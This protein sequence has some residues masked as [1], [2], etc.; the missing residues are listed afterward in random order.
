MDRC[1]A[2]G[3]LRPARFQAIFERSCDGFLALDH[4]A[5]PVPIELRQRLLDD[6]DLFGSA[7]AVAAVRRGATAPQVRALLRRVSG[8]DAVVDKIAA[9]GAEARYRRVL[10]AV[11]ELEAL[12]VTEEGIEEQILEFLSRDDTLVARMAAAVDLA[13][14]D[15]LVSGADVLVTAMTRPAHLQRATRWQRYSLRPPRPPKLWTGERAT[16]CLWRGYRQR[17]VAALVA[18]ARGWGRAVTG[19]ETCSRR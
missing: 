19:P 4:P 5:G 1:A 7:L 11:A 6:F 10:D 18:D 2:A 14:A 15:G 9:L 17:I 16:P 12:A 3:R 8:V 13:E